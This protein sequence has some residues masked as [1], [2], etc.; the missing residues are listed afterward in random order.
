MVIRIKKMQRSFD[1]IYSSTATAIK[2]L[3]QSLEAWEFENFKSKFI[4]LYKTLD[5]FLESAKPARIFSRK[6]DATTGNA[7]L[8]WDS[9]GVMRRLILQLM[10]LVIMSLTIEELFLP[11]MENMN[12]MV[13]FK[14]RIECE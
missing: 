11:W 5:D 7:I 14:V 12:L 9:L 13:S 10:S 3:S 6:T 2:E 1:S 8:T 4:A